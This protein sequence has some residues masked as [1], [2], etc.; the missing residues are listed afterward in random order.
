MNDT[1]LLATDRVDS[2]KKVRQ[3]GFTPAVLNENDTTSTSVQFNSVDLS[4]V[5]TKH[6]N[7]AKVWITLGDKKLFGFVKDIQRDPIVRN[8]THVSIQIVSLDQDVKMH[9]PILFHKVDVLEHRLLHLL[10]VKAEIEVSGKATNMPDSVAADV[11]EKMAGDTITALDFSLPEGI[12][13]QDSENEIY[14]VIK[15]PKDYSIEEDEAEVESVEEPKDD[16]KD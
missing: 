7:K 9:L 12:I 6:G 13:V 5:I 16:S 8:I 4:K 1:L 2:V 14:A 10:V 3:S 11:S 15:V